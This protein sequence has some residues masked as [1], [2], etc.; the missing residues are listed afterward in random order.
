MTARTMTAVVAAVLVLLAGCVGAGSPSVAAQSVEASADERGSTVTVGASATVEAAPDLA[1]V[2]VAVEATAE[3]AEEARASVAADAERMRA[4]LRE[5]GVPDANVSTEAFSVYPQYDY[6]DDTRELVGY[7]AV[8]AYRIEVAPDR[9][10]EAIDVAVGNGAT[11]ASGVSFT[12]SDAA[13]QE[14]RQE[15]LTAAMGNARADAETVA[16]AAGATL[17]DARTISTSNGGSVGPFPA[18]ESRSDAGGST[19]VEPGP[20]SVTASVTVV[21][22]VA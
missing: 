19:V 7:R 2:R 3:S 6:S 20:V 17:G 21:Y 5:A 22:G 12:L 11:S 13:E 1:V 14:L 15:A 16:A 4:A 8:H 10:G 9:A 18:F